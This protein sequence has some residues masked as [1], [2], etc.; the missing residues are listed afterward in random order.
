MVNEIDASPLDKGAAYFAATMYK[1]DDN[2]PYLYKTS[3]YGKTWTKITDGIPAGQFT[4]VVR[5]DTNRRGLL[6]A[7]TERGTF[8]SVDEG[9]H[10][11]SRRLKL[12]ITPV[13]DLR[14]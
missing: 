7:G 1:S 3:D 8:I 5:S 4:R 11:Q 10:W 13:P 6:F 14:S 12:P 9:A 2:H